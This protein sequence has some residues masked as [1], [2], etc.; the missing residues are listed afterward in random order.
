MPMSGRQC[1]AA[2]ALLDMA[3]GELGR[4]AK[5]NINTLSDFEN[6][7]RATHPRTVEALQRALEAAGIEFLEENGGGPGLRLKARAG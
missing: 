3:Q 4:L 7:S 1:R 6:G 5:V 2:R